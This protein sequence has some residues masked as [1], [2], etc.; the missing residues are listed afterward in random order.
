[1]LSP[2]WVGS[3]QSLNSKDQRDNLKENEK[4]LNYPK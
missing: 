1:M 4:F 3:P 2:V